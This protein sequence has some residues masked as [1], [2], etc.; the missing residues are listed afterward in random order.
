MLSNLPEKAVL[1]L[2]ERKSDDQDEGKKVFI[3]IKDS[4][5]GIDSSI[6]SHLFSKFATK[7]FHGTGLGLFISNNI[8]KSHGGEMWAKNNEDGK[9]GATFG[10]S[11]SVANC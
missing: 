3:H 9:K 2:L 10:F 6:L 11:L 8:I 7:S 4:G 1:K 5:S